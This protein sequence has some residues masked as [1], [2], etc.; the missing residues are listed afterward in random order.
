MHASTVTI[1]PVTMP[2]VTLTSPL[3]V[4]ASFE[5][6]L[7]DGIRLGNVVGNMLGSTVGALDGTTVGFVLE[8]SFA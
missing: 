4:L 7:F 1:T 3:S 6:A 5:Y 8:G 2:I